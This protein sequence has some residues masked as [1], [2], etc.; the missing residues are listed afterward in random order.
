MNKKIGVIGGAGPYASSLLY[1]RFITACYDAGDAVPEMVL[2]N[3]PFTR[4]LLLEEYT[5]RHTL[6]VEELQ[7]CFDRLDQQGV[8]VAVIACNT[9]HLF[10]SDVNTRGIV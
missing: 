5:G 8:D 1:Q 2:L 4:V 6:L 9:L 10:L 3:F 7:E